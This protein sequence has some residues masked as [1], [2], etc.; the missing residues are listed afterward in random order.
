MT[1]PAP[2]P[3]EMRVFPRLGYNHLV[4]LAGAS[5]SEASRWDE[6]EGPERGSR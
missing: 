4:P 6:L 5:W 1:L 2:S 3:K